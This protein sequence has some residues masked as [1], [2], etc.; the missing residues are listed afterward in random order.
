MSMQEVFEHFA[1]LAAEGHPALVKIMDDYVV[2]KREALVAKLEEKYTD[3]LYD[4]IGE[5]NP[6]GE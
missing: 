3:N 2:S 5:M 6:F 4:V 1:S